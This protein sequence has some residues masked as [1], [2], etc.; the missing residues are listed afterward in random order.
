M[1]HY[2]KIVIVTLYRDTAIYY[3]R[4]FYGSEILTLRKTEQTY[5]ENFEMWCWR[6]MEKMNWNYHV[7][8]ELLLRG[9][10]E[11]NIIIQ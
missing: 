8:H 6:R 9:K 5:L 3:E 7:R 4:S 10:E 1:S 2:R 11:R